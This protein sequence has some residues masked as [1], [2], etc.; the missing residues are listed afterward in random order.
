MVTTAMN[1]IMC[2]SPGI[3]TPSQ[4]LSKPQ[5]LP[6][7]AALPLRTIPGSYGWPLLGP[8][9]D[10]LDYFWFQ[11]PET[12]FRKRME[13]HKSSVFRTNVPPTFPFFTGVNPNVIAVLDCKSFAHLFDMEIVEKKDV[14]VGDFMPSIKFT[15]GVRVCAYL[16][17]SEP[18]HGQIKNLA[19]DVLKRS[20]KVWVSE[21]LSNLSNFFDTIDTKVSDTGSASYIVSLQQCV[22]N[23]LTKSL[24]GADPALEPD[25]AQ[26]GYAMLDRWLALQ[27]LPT[28]KIGVLQPLEEIFLHSFPYP[29]ALVSGDY[30][31]LYKF[32]EQ[33]GR[34]VLERG[35]KEFGLTASDTIHNLLFVLGFNAFGGFSVFLPTLIGVIAADKT[36][37]QSRLRKEVKEKCGPGLDFESVKNLE[38]VKSVVYETLRV[39]PPVPLQYARARKDFRLSSHDSAYEIK[40]GE[41]LC[42]YQTLAMRDGQVFDEPESF[43]PDRFTGE[44]GR[45]LLDYL[46]WSNGPQT[47]TPTES[48]KQCAGKDYVTLTGCLV[49]ASMF[50]RYECITGDSSSITAVVKAK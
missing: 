37:L 13:K 9:S 32:I 31:K 5:S 47:E 28:V 35:E 29:F 11:G 25:I 23:F 21:L 24:I 30:N 22:F 39:N 43:K 50:Q 33:N 48:N 1:K 8:I 27:L 44:E 34:E 12:F 41:L 45:K 4:S 7:T 40:K 2:A 6:S 14:L 16:D 42:G 36:G 15:G 26:S 49:V 3:P 10:R 17:T 19:L 18:Q 20:S 38:L 46:Y